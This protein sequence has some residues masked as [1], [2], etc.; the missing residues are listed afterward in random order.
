VL[1]GCNGARLVTE[2][3]RWSVLGDPTEGA[4]LT[5]GAKASVHAEGVEAELPEL[6][7]F[8]FDS[9]RKRMSVIRRRPDQRLVALV[10]GAPDVL[11]ERCS[12]ALDGG[13]VVPLG[14]ALRARI[15]DSNSE[16]ALRGLR[17]LAAAEHEITAEDAARGLDEVE[18]DL[19]FVGLVGMQDPPRAEAK[20]A[21]QRCKEA[22]IRVTMITGDQPATALAIAKELGIADASDE[23][24]AGAE[25]DRMSEPELARR[26]PRIAVYARVTAAHKLRIV[27]AHRAAGNVVAMTGDGVNDAPA[28]KGADIGIAMGKSGTEVTKEA[29]DM[30][31]TDDDFATIVAAVEEGRGAYANIR[32][33]L[34]Y[35]LAGN[36]GELLLVAACVTAG[37][38]IPLLAVHL[39][40]INLV[41]DG[42]PALCLAI[43]PIDEDVMK[44]PPRA[45]EERMADRSFLARMLVTGC[46]TASVAFAVYAIE[47]G[48]H[49]QAM[50]RAHTFSALVF[51]ELLRSFGCRSDTKLV[52]EL[53]LATNLKLLVVVLASFTLQLAAPHLP[54]LAAILR[55]PAMPFTHCLWLAAVGSIPLVVLEAWKL[56]SRNRRRSW[57]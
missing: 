33:T 1:V 12:H 3:G 8:P 31:I 9:D 53:G 36:T 16:M 54:W 13:A 45:R 19:V 56:I 29:S 15:R 5:A 25:L 10:K 14:D 43:D 26:A 7:R 57:R 41:T 2:Q 17:V 21:V 4:L 50:A 24:V 46:L 27:R 51:A 37:L 20:R 38:P 35:L 49:D 23:A 39:L 47:S 6:R 40:W 44:R 55:M 28:I 18:R 34:Q 42:L 48:H 22:G 11:L 30:V 32:K 52:T